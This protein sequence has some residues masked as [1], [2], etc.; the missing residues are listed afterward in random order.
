MDTI[1]TETSTLSPSS[2]RSDVSVGADEDRALREKLRFWNERPAMCFCLY[3]G[4]FVF[5]E[6]IVGITL[7]YIFHIA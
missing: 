1:S 6:V 4:V 3:F 7:H 2:K 5:A